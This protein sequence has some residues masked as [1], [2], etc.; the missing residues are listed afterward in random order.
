MSDLATEENIKECLHDLYI[1]P[2]RSLFEWS[3]ITGQTPQVRLAYPGEHLASII[4]GVEGAGTAA[5]GDDLSDGTEV[6]SCSRA[7]QLSEC[8]NCGGKVL[9]WQEECSECG[10]EDINIKTDSHWIISITSRKELNLYLDRVPRVILMMFDRESHDTD[11]IRLRAWTVDPNQWYYRAFLTDYFENNYQVKSNP[12]PCNLHPEKYDFYMMEPHLI[13]HAD[14]DIEDD[15]V[16]IEYWDVDDP[17]KEPMPTNTANLDQ[18]E[19][20]FSEEELHDRVMDLPQ[21]KRMEYL[22]SRD[23][24]KLVKLQKKDYVELF[25]HIPEEKRGDLKMKDKTLKTMKKEYQR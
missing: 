16:Y 18:L 10:S 5:R 25:P 9:V 13:F 4:T 21:E 11:E 23:R 7:D 12:A 20:L 17:K 19:D 8:N 15:E 2:R 22:N 1:E 6:K 14:I 3:E 24:S